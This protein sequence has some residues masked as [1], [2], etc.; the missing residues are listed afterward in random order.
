MV[1]GKCENA[2]VRCRLWFSSINILLVMIAWRLNCCQCLLCICVWYLCRNGDLADTDGHGYSKVCFNIFDTL[3]NIYSPTDTI[4]QL[5]WRARSSVCSITGWESLELKLRVSVVQRMVSGYSSPFCWP[6][7][8]SRY[9]PWSL[10]YGQCDARPM[11]TFLAS[12]HHRTLPSSNQ[13]WL[14]EGGTCDRLSSGD[15]WQCS[16]ESWT[17]HPLIM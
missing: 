10:I 5:I 11:V 12:D 3:T 15:T 16:G 2:A 13:Y 9:I 17:Q 1:S 14:D 8:C 4:C 7:V 6:C